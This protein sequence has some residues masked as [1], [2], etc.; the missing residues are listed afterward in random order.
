MSYSLTYQIK[1]ING[2]FVIPIRQEDDI[3]YICAKIQKDF[4]IIPKLSARIYGSELQG[5][6][7][8]SQCVQSQDV[9][10]FITKETD[11]GHPNLTFYR[12]PIITPRYQSYSTF[13]VFT[14]VN[15]Q[16]MTVGNKIKVDVEHDN[17]SKIEKTIKDMLKSKYSKLINANKLKSIK[18][19]LYLPGGIPFLDGTIS[20]FIES[21]PDFMPHLYAIILYDKTITDKVLEKSFDTVCNISTPEMQSLISPDHQSDTYSLCEIASVLGYIQQKGQSVERMIYSIA[22][23]CH[24]APMICGLYSLANL[25]RVTGRT[26]IQITAP[27]IQLFTQM[28]KT[29]ENQT[30]LF[31][32]TVKFLTY[33]MNIK[34][35]DRIPCTE[36]IRPFYNI[37]YEKYFHDYFPESKFPKLE[38][39]IAFDPD[40]RDQDWIGF[41]IP[42]LKESDFENAMN[43]TK[44]LDIIPPMSLRE[45]HRYSLFQ[46]QNG[47]WLFLAASVSK[48]ETERDKIDYINPEK[49]YV[50]HDTYENIAVKSIG[51]DYKNKSISNQFDEK[52]INSIDP[53]KVTQLVF[54]VIDKSGSMCCGF[55]AGN[56]SWNAPIEKNRFTASQKFFVKFT[57]ACYR[58]HTTSLYG[59]I[60]FNHST[61]V[62]NQLNPLVSNFRER[63]IIPGE[64]PSGG[65]NMFSAMKMGADLLLRANSDNKYPNAVLRLIVISDGED[66][67]SKNMQETVSNFILQNHIRVDAIIVSDEVARELVAISRFTGGIAICPQT[68]EEGLELFNKEEFFNVHLRQFGQMRAPNVTSQ[69]LSELPR[70]TVNQ[71]D[72]EIHIK[73]NEY[74][75]R[76]KFVVSPIH[77]IVDYDKEVNKHFETGGSLHEV[78]QKQ[79]RIINELRKINS[80]PDEDIRVFPLK[81]RVDVWRVLIKGIEGSAYEGCW[82]YMI[83][84]FLAEYPTH[85]PLFR[86]I[87]PPFHPNITD[88]GRVCMDS[89]DQRYRSDM[90]ILEL[91]GD[92]KLLL[93]EPN[94]D[95]CVDLKREQHREEMVEYQRRRALAKS[96]DQEPPLPSIVKEWNDRNSKGSP[97]EWENDWKIEKDDDA[98]KNLQKV[99]IVP[100]QFLCPISRKIMR[101]PVK[102]TSGVYYEKVELEKYLKSTQNP[103]CRA[104]VDENGKPIPLPPEKNMGL[105]VDNQMKTRIT[106]W[107]KANDYREDEEEGNEEENIV[108]FNNTGQKIPGVKYAILFNEGA[109]PVQLAS[110]S[111]SRPRPP[112]SE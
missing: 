1:G 16:S 64:R 104:K 14:T 71:L 73:P 88:Q 41:E 108:Y 21:F 37:G 49:G 85:Y 106:Q 23:F 94:F 17:I 22:K 78:H 13:I 105:K 54:I 110:H 53:V 57:E 52:V 39:F 96:K 24:F 70:L 40:F 98:L 45:M 26:I 61:E 28:D 107:I 27:L 65:T 81:D 109:K 32:S 72:K 111:K 20:N 89:L 29:L 11:K 56:G 91:L 55:G 102:A 87:H 35:S 2:K 74:A 15:F 92:I 83:I 5:S 82:F 66:G 30:N 44:T 19:L 99:S 50:E 95:S 47:P 18:L 79:K 9:I 76:E 3:K 10:T 25:S 90:S 36:F 67:D 31:S 100:E 7:I 59:S 38:N 97:D 103:T 68:I 93:L 75:D 48:E 84:E 77:A 8:V 43:H 4:G 112:L 62:R 60:M 51:I 34:I 12:Q 6:N 63:M 46:G 101:E 86:F 69:E 58:F 42:N 80:N 33:F